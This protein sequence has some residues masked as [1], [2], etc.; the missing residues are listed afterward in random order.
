MTKTIRYD[1]KKYF[2]LL[3]V[4]GKWHLI[5]ERYDI[6]KADQYE[7]Y[8]ANHHYAEPEKK[9]SG[10][11]SVIVFM[12]EQCN[13]R[14]DYC[15]V[16][17]MITSPNKKKTDAD[18][19]IESLLESLNWTEGEVNIIFYGGEPLLKHSEINDICIELS[20]NGKG[21][22]IYSITTNGTLLNDEIL[23]ML[24][25]H[26]IRIGVSMDG[27][28]ALHDDHRTYIGRD[29]SH[30]LVSK[31]YSIMKGAGLQCGPI[32]VITDPSSYIESFDYFV[33]YF[34]DTFIYL[35]PLDVTGLETCCELSN[36]FEILLEQQLRLLRRNVIAF[37]AGKTK[38]IETHTM[39]K[40]ENIL[41]SHDPGIKTCK[42]DYNSHC[43]INKT[44]KG[45]EAD[46]TVIPCPTM[47]KHSGWDQ[48]KIQVIE[49]KNGYCEGCDYSSVCTSFCLG[50]MDASYVHSFVEQGNTEHVDI[51]CHY[52]KAFIDAVFD[53]LREKKH[54]ITSY[55]FN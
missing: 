2:V 5:N 50:E 10:T 49:T 14:C 6:A 54:D 39:T 44:I 17:Q 42:N 32:C 41:L 16:S 13:L 53:M 28:Q 27:N 34:N 8:V 23:Q 9:D 4:S 15:K 48:E 55:V 40:L 1:D 47:K 11:L 43:S 45:V 51:I 18:R 24:V 26:Q 31:N 7:S 38:L 52:N 22:F 29:G 33:E 12:T 20:R 21:R 37:S 3:Q 19:I 36:Y 25:R 46:G 35:K 30:H